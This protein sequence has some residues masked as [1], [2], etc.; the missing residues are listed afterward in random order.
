[1]RI[2]SIC[3][4]CDLCCGQTSP[5]RRRHLTELVYQS[6]WSRRLH[7]VRDAIGDGYVDLAGLGFLAN[8][9]QLITGWLARYR[10][11]HYRQ[12]DDPQEVQALDEIGLELCD[13]LV[14]ELPG[15]KIGY[16]SVAPMEKMK[17]A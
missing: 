10:T 11:A 2:I 15:N 13:R 14:Q 9:V 12:F 7:R 5:I 4:I 8:V 6:E 17:S 3:K 1:M 16:F